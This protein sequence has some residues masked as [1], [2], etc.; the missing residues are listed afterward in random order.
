MAVEMGQEPSTGGFFSD[1]KNV[2]IAA[3]L[4]GAGAG[5]IFLLARR[6]ST[7]SEDETTRTGAAADATDIQ[8]GNLASQ[9][10][11]FRGDW[12]VSAAAMSA[13]IA[14]NSVDNQTNFAALQDLVKG[15]G[16]AGAADVGNLYRTV[17]QYGNYQNAE[18]AKTQ[19]LLTFF[20]N[21]GAT[22]QQLANLD[23]TV[24][25]VGADNA[26]ASLYWASR[27][28][29][30]PTGAGGSSFRDVLWNTFDTS[31]GQASEARAAVASGPVRYMHL[32][33]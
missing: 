4:L 13:N 21:R 25:M 28:S 16:D 27:Q 12:S 32:A 15:Y 8:L 20:G 6:N 14:K 33:K 24:R 17:V 19:Q 10:L 30:V 31:Q 26:A 5:L 11:G 22:A 23:N 3:G 18:E 7:P 1:R 2:L 9:L 29:T